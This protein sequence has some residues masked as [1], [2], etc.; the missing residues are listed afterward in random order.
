MKEKAKEIPVINLFKFY[1]GENN[2]LSQ[3]DGDIK[4]QNF[5]LK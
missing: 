3:L 5:I 2:H 4:L 1:F